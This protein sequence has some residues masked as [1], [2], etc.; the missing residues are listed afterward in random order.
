MFK[1]VSKNNSD[2]KRILNDVIYYKNYLHTFCFEES[3]ELL[4]HVN[5]KQLKVF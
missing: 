4:D 3:K 1:I 5:I 2:I